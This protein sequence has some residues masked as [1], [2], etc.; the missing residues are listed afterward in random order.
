MAWWSTGSKPG[1]DNFAMSRKSSATFAY[2]DQLEP[3]FDVV[4]KPLVNEPV[5]GTPCTNHDCR[6]IFGFAV[7]GALTSGQLATPLKPGVA[8]KSPQ[9]PHE[10]NVILPSAAVGTRWR[11]SRKKPSQ[12]NGFDQV[13]PSSVDAHRLLSCV[14]K[15]KSWRP[16]LVIH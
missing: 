13:A 7:G 12:Q 3:P 2:C 11:R 15:Y 8:T 14:P 6:T 4:A 5:V 1:S 9:G 10:T 16:R